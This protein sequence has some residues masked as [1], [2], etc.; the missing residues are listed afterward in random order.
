MGE[1]YEMNFLIDLIVVAIMAILM[2]GGYR[3]GLIH[4]VVEL[5]GAA[6]SSII[7]SFGAS[8]ISAGVYEAFVKDHIINAI[9]EAMPK[10]N[11]AANS[12][13][14]T[15]DLL[16]TLP[17]YMKNSLDMLGISEKSISDEITST[18]MNIPAMLETMIRPVVMR[19]LTVIITIVLFA[20]LATIIALATKSLTTVVD[21]T[22]LSTTN[23]VLGAI[24]GLI[25]ALVIVMVM[26]LILYFMS[27]MLPVDAAEEL[28]K[29]IDS[30]FIYKMIDR[31]N[32]PEL[33][34]SKLISF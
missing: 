32:I 31:F 5:V 16:N 24:L 4:S 20:L 19:V 1:V 25:E 7:A 11:A 3:R 2:I 12:A 14:Y 22:G 34:M 13:G 8:L 27:V 26:S 21:A 30:T 17:E 10:T 29:A 33:I 18:E 6:V 9:Q 15:A 23:K 28:R